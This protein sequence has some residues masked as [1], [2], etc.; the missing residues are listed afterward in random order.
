MA[1]KRSIAN[2]ILFEKNLHCVRMLIKSVLYP[3]DIIL[4]GGYWIPMKRES[5]RDLVKKWQNKQLTDSTQ[6][7]NRQNLS[8]C[9]SALFQFLTTKEKTYHFEIR[10]G[11][12]IRKRNMN[13]NFTLRDN[14]SKFKE[15]CNSF[16]FFQSSS[17][18]LGELI[19]NIAKTQSQD[20]WNITMIV[21]GP[22][23]KSR[24]IV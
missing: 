2:P 1:W 12:K 11:L 4:G 19:F 7:K 8:W 20:S 22:R 15:N 6:T 23:R 3:R 9:S 14:H 16:W 18:R 24:N 17:V 5:Y 21:W 10:E 13:P